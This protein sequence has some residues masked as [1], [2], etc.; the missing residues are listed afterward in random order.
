MS[1]IPS[2]CPAVLRGGAIVLRPQK[3]TWSGMCGGPGAQMCRPAVPG[4]P[5]TARQ[6]QQAAVGP[7]SL[8]EGMEG[9]GLLHKLTLIFLF[10]N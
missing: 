5:T 8:G 7:H 4:D 6:R 2:D 1:L 3:G 9:R 10:L